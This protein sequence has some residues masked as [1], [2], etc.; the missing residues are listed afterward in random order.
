MWGRSSKA[1]DYI[2]TQVSVGLLASFYRPGAFHLCIM[3]RNSRTDKKTRPQINKNGLRILRE[4]LGVESSQGIADFAKVLSSAIFVAIDFEQLQKLKEDDTSD[5]EGQVGIA[6]L[7]TDNLKRPEKIKPAQVISTFNF[8]CGPPKYCAK[9]SRDF[10]F[11]CS[12]VITR[13]DM[14]KSIDSVIP[15]A[16]NIVLVGHHVTRDLQALQLLKFDFCAVN[17]ILDTLW[18]AHEVL[19]CTGS[20]RDLL[21]KLECPFD[22]LHCA[23]NDAHFT[24][25]LL[26]L[27]AAASISNHQ[28]QLKINLNSIGHAPLPFRIDRNAIALKKKDK[29]LQRSRKYQSQFWDLE[30]KTAIRAER[31][32]RK[33]ESLKE[34][35]PFT[36]PVDS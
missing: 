19:R 6:I 18:I 15:P 17:A 32:A 13:K 20:L 24:L 16:R 5:V 3:A 21:V 27:L 1:A 26:L 8:T 9:A 10:L 35:N 7:D 14:R 30:K 11:G 33:T 12:K 29:R 4:T 31:A 22:K 25:R 23:G 28:S 36:P 34:L 2:S